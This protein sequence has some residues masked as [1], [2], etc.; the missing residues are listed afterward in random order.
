[1]KSITLTMKRHRNLFRRLLTMEHCQIQ[2]LRA[3]QSRAEQSRFAL[4]EQS[5]NQ[6]K[7]RLQTVS[8]Q[9]MTQE[10]AACGQME[11]WLLKDM[12]ETA[13]KQIDVAVTLRARDYK[14]L[15]NYGSNGVI[16]WKN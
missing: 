12:G 6:E 7:K 15:D 11:T 2:F 4:T 14:G 1:M 5:V 10:S 8:R 3:E 9:D 13:E 16:E